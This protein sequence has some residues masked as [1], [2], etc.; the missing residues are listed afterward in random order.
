MPNTTSLFVLKQRG[1]DWA[2]FQG[3]L[4]LNETELEAVKSLRVVK[5]EYTEMFYIQD[6]GR[7]VLRIT[8]D[9]LSYW[10]CTSDPLDKARIEKAMGENKNLTQMEVLQKLAASPEAA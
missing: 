9:P 4:G 2:D 5:G 10:I 1:I 7:A 3:R 6:E 8:P